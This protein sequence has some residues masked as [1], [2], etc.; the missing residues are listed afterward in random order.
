MQPEAVVQ[1]QPQVTKDFENVA[2][3][4]FFL[5]SIVSGAFCFCGCWWAIV[6]CLPAFFFAYLV[7]VS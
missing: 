6:C 1:E 3:S 4:A 2:D 7:S 5:A